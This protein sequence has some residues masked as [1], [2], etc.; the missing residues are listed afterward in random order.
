MSKTYEHDKVIEAG[1][2]TKAATEWHTDLI[3]HDVKVCVVM[4][5]VPIG[6]DGEPTCAAV[7]LAGSPAYAKTKVNSDRDRLLTKYSALIEI[8]KMRWNELPDKS[9][10][11]LL[12]HEL[13]HL[14]VKHDSDGR[15]VQNDD[16]T[17]K[18]ETRP[19]DWVLTGFASVAKRHGE[20]ALESRGF[21]AVFRVHQSE[22]DFMTA[23]A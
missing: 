16:L 3:Q 15:V 7:M 9:K 13:E 5:E 19:D 23:A 12:D 6:D 10:M 1:F 17:A 4:V 22:F 14:V 8:D 21:E 11:A 2:L 18:L 20:F